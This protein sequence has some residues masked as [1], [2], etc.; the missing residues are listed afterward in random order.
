MFYEIWWQDFG[1]DGKGC[2]LIVQ[3]GVSGWSLYQRSGTWFRRWC[4]QC[5]QL[6]HKMKLVN[7]ICW[8]MRVNAIK[9]IKNITKINDDNN[10][11][12]LRRTGPNLDMERWLLARSP[13]NIRL[14]IR[15]SGHL[16]QEAYCRCC[17]SFATTFCICHI[18]VMTNWWIF[19]DRFPTPGGKFQTHFLIR[20][21]PP[22][23]LHSNKYIVS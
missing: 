15:T 19:C 18:G 23:T 11:H 13:N 14:T 21:K 8:G 16:T 22:S 20:L 5:V 2:R 1:F 9:V 12:G 17:T 4:C 10:W 3:F 7:N 6:R